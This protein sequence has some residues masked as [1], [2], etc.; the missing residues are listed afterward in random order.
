[1]KK[2]LNSSQRGF[3]L[4]ETFVAVLI[5][6]FAVIGPLGLLSRAIA[7]G[8]YAKN[9]VT[10]YYLAQEAVEL[11]INQ[12][13]RNLQNELINWTQPFDSCDAGSP[14]KVYF[15]SSLRVE[16]CSGENCRMYIN[17]DRYTHRNEGSQSLFRRYLY[18]SGDDQKADL[19]VVVEWLNKDQP[20]NFTL[21]TQV[22]NINYGI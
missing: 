18:L 12:R 9:Q 3:T 5:L 8:N 6:V 14:C 22:F 2:I 11:F 21:N 4:I 15:D 1:M 10:A 16:P 20:V 13:D 19:S 17:N 7:D